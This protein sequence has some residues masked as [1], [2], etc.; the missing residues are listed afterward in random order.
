MVTARFP[1]S[2]L[3]VH[4][5]TSVVSLHPL[6]FLYPGVG[7]GGWIAVKAA[8]RGGRDAG[9]KQ[10]TVPLFE[11]CVTLGTC[12]AFSALGFQSMKWKSCNLLAGFF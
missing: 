1:S 5:C 7:G 6:V 3:L 8:F 2:V 9:V 4:T 12:F 11:S 10:T